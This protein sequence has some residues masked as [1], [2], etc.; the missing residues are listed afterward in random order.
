MKLLSVCVLCVVAFTSISCGQ[1]V[2]NST[3]SELRAVPE[4]VDFGDVAPGNQSERTISLTVT[5]RS[6]VNV[7]GLDI[8]GDS[9][10]AFEVLDVVSVVQAG[11]PAAVKI[12]FH[13]GTVTG[14]QTATLKIASQD[15]PVLNVPLQVRVIGLCGQAACL[16]RCGTF[17]DDCGASVVCACDAGVGSI[18]YSNWSAF[19]ACS[20]TC[21][22]GTEQ[23]TRTC[24]NG[25]SVAVDCQQCGGMCTEE[26]ACNGSTGCSTPAYTPWGSW[27]TC[28]GGMQTRQ[29]SCELNGS[30]VAC[31]DCGGR[32]SEN[33][34]CGSCSSY[35]INVA[36]CASRAD[37]DTVLVTKQASCVMAGC[38]WSGP[39]VCSIGGSPSSATCYG[40]RGDCR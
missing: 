17:P 40:G 6:S 10:A 31:A 13:A 5:N 18:M 39:T 32:C 14:S 3:D 22:A 7:S 38:S 25:N 36:N 27:S 20:N 15:A 29:R 30:T 19:G 16:G 4:S 12:R 8:T 21:G 33:Q 26:R 2:T 35:S 23:R 37:C 1:T 24:V 9:A 11:V 28:T 34:S